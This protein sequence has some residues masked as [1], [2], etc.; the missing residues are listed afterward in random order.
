MRGMP[1]EKTETRLHRFAVAM[2]KTLAA[3]RAPRTCRIRTLAYDDRILLPAGRGER[4]VE[5]SA[6]ERIHAEG[7]YSEVRLCDGTKGLLLRSLC[8][9]ERRLP[10][11]HFIRIHRSTIINVEA[12]ERVEP[13]FN[14]SFRIFLRNRPEPLVSSRRYSAELRARFA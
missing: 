7:D 6:I 4:L 9:W 14:S 13:W 12:I 5:V 2:R 3:A 10:R 1:A 8:E 11:K